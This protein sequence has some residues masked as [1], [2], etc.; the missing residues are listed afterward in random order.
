MVAGAPR[1]TT[2]EP[3]ECIE[4]G[5][6]F[7][8]WL[9]E[10]NGE[11]KTSF[12]FWYAIK[13]GMV[14][15][16]WKALVKTPEF[17]PYYEVGRAYMAKEIHSQKLEKGLGHR[18][19]RLYDRELAAEEDETK[20]YDAKLKLEVDKEAG[21]EVPDVLNKILDSLNKKD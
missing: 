6:D 13:H 18:Y 8:K 7:I 20:L 16:V 17:R 9:T 10:D 5:K 11:L 4:L 3:E 1:T 21:K 12:Q 2:P 15:D 19:I 14:R